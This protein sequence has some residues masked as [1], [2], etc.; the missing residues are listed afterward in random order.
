MTRPARL[1]AIGPTVS[2]RRPRARLH[3]LAVPFVLLC[4]AF[5]PMVGG[6]SPASAD[7]GSQ[8][9]LAEKYL[10]VVRL[11][12]QSGACGPGEPFRPSNVD[13][14][15]GNDGVA[16]R[17]PWTTADLVDLA[18]TAQDLSKPLYGYA[19]DLPGDPLKPGCT[20]EQWFERTWARSPMTVYAHV[21]T[22]RGH[23][24]QLALQY[25]FYYP[26]NDFNN[27]HESDWEMVQVEFDAA[28]ADEALGT[29]P[30]RTVY[31][32]HEGS[33]QADWGSSKL[34]VVGGSHPTVFVSAGSH[35]NH[36]GSALFLLRS[37]NQGLG[38]DTTLNPDPGVSPVV[39]TIPSNPVLAARLYPWTRYQ[40]GWGQA[41]ARSFYSGPTGPEAKDSW[42]RPFTWS[43][44]AGQRSYAVPGGAVYG[45]KTTDFFCGAVAQVSMALL[46]FTANPLPVLVALVLV[47][48]VVV[49]LIRRASWDSARALPVRLRRT[50]AETVVSAWLA[51]RKAPLVFLGIGAVIAVVAAASGLVR[52]MVTQAPVLAETAPTPHG[53]GAVVAV[54][55]VVLTGITTLISN[56]ATVQVLADLGTGEPVTIRDAYR[57]ALR[58]GVALGGTSLLF[59]VVLAVLILTVWLAPLAL[60]L[61]VLGSVMTPVVQLEGRGGARA[62]WRSV[63]LVRHQWIKA[64]SVIVFGALLAALVGGLLG[65]ALLLA[66]QVP[67][68]VVN[69]IPGV[70]FALLGPVVSLLLGYVYFHG[71]AA[72]EA[73]VP[74]PEAS[75]QRDREPAPR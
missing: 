66:F 11:V 75:P 28:T 27:K 3:L 38:C 37:T 52:Q 22:Q 20:Y 39:Q 18:P 72:E 58:R 56:A 45:V 71:L 69:L 10:P 41:E 57:K 67:F 34:Q 74:E 6:A 36:Y 24:G 63:R 29:T 1:G 25:W 23:P 55:G 14:L 8:Q 7:I 47:L 19:L 35:S 26:F 9:A 2:G 68:I 61:V 49:W 15:F 60:V 53:W 62:I 50:F 65:S 54:A 32:A 4:A 51:Y 73:R 12:H 21:A 64:L 59:A 48:L 5:L 70:V 33:E 44:D 13:R 16:L 43:Q 31:S 40:G 42:T 46:A 30:T 17:G